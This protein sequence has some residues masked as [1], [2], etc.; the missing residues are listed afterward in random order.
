M[1]HQHTF[2]QFLNLAQ[3]NSSFTVFPNAACSH[4]YQANF[5]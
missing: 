2:F 1:T 4:L 5:G 3:R